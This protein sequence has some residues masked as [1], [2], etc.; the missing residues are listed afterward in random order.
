MFALGKLVIIENKSDY[1]FNIEV[2][3]HIRNRDVHT[4]W[5][6]NVFGSAIQQTP[7]VPSHPNAVLSRHPFPQN[8]LDMTGAEPYVV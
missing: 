8:L 3:R 4:M 6:A 5:T 7:I 2:S 1:I